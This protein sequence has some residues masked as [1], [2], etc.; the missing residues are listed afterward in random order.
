MDIKELT[1]KSRKMLTI[2]VNELGLDGDSY[3]QINEPIFM[4]G[5]PPIQNDAKGQY[6]APD[7]KD[8]YE[9]LNN[10]TFN[11]ETIEKIKSNGLILINPIYNTEEYAKELVVTA[12]HE[13]IHANRDV[14]LYDV[15]QNGEKNESS[16]LVDPTSRKIE[17]NTSNFS[18]NHADASQDILKGVIDNAQSTID[19]YN[20]KTSNELTNMNNSDKKV[21]SLIKKQINIDETL[22][23]IMSILAYN[24]SIYKEKNISADIWDIL[25]DLSCYSY[26]NPLGTMS[27]IILDHHDFEL[28]N[29]M[30]DPIGYSNGDI[31]YDF[32]KDYTKNDEDLL[33][34][35]YQELA[36]EEEEK[37]TM[38]CIKEMA[39]SDTALREANSNINLFEQ[40]KTS[41]EQKT[42]DR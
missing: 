1:E 12:I 5:T 27:D 42:N 22:V 13:R 36:K 29:W 6:L 10:H 9:F 39:L 2:F 32:F 18:T 8:L 14:L 34:E 33:I 20:S 7:E 4:F 21:K 17:Q 28:F 26:G 25:D 40:I 35:F 16:Y 11:D 23:E 37:I 3:V 38:Q 41:A 24:L 15:F 31:H 30:I 19:S